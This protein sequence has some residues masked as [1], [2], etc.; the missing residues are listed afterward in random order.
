MKEEIEDTDYLFIND[1]ENNLPKKQN[2]CRKPHNKF[3]HV[4]SLSDSEST[5]DD[6]KKS[7]LPTFSLETN[8]NKIEYLTNSIREEYYSLSNTVD[9]E[10]ALNIIRTLY[11]SLY[12]ETTEDCPIL[13]H[14]VNNIEYM[15]PLDFRQFIK[16]QKQQQQQQQQIPL[17]SQDKDESNKKRKLTDSVIHFNNNSNDDDNNTIITATVIEEPLLKNIH[18]E[19]MRDGLMRAD[20]I[21]D[22]LLMKPV[23]EEIKRIDPEYIYILKDFEYLYNRYIN[24]PIFLEMG[25]YNSPKNI[26]R[27]KIY[28]AMRSI[29]LVS[30]R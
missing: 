12:T 13:C 6:E 19:Y 15:E 17:L 5:I 14:T 3:I 20:D 27:N 2:T 24:D 21:W 4:I 30:L 22:H 1:P 18:C 9:K 10:N 29:Y 7:S 26:Y 11:Y 16:K 28:S 23:K 8:N 25:K